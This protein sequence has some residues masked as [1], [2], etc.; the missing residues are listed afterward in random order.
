MYRTPFLNINRKKGRLS[1]P[2]AD[3]KR[4]IIINMAIV[5]ASQIKGVFVYALRGF[6]LRCRDEN[7]SPAFLAQTLGFTKFYRFIPI[8]I[9]SVKRLL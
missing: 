9:F 7:S 3:H 2:Q 5:S 4:Q 6:S 8:L 1:P